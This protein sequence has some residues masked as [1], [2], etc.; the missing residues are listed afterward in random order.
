MSIVLFACE[1]DPQC[2]PILPEALASALGER[3]ASDDAAPLAPDW[4]QSNGVTTCVFFPNPYACRRDTAVLLG[5]EGDGEGSWSRPGGAMPITASAFF[6][7]DEHSLEIGTDAVASRTLWYYQDRDRFLA[8]TSQRAIVAA[9]GSFEENTDVRAWMLLTGSIG[10]GLSWDR[11]VHALPGDAVL[12]LDRRTW[13]VDIDRRPQDWRV[14]RVLSRRGHLER[15]REALD[16]TFDALPYRGDMVVPISGGYDSRGILLHMRERHGNRVVGLTWG[17]R[18]ALDR[19]DS[20][21]DIA[22]RLCAALGVKHV[23]YEIDAQQR[24]FADVFRRFVELGEGRTDHISG[25]ADGFALWRPMA[26]DGIRCILRGDIPIDGAL[27]ATA[28]GVRTHVELPRWHDIQNARDT[29][30]DGLV[31]VWPSFLDRQ[32]GERLEVWTNR[33]YQEFRHGSVFS[34]LTHLKTRYVEVINPLL[35]RPI[36]DRLRHLP[37]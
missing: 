26:G 24:P 11:R 3:L 34:A 36:V 35:S 13:T 7:S 32:P 8:S 31:Q 28:H 20:D 22:R 5:A 25:Y 4:V 6:R 19:K 30:L 15:L 29:G 2:A 12:R 21:A 1:R 14:D 16:E 18:E 37:P 27:P 33:L 23:F 9:L 10:P 17:V